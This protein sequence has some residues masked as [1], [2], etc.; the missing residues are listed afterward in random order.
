MKW[1]SD[2]PAVTDPALAAVAGGIDELCPNATV[3]GVLRHV[4]DRRVTTLVSTSDDQAIL[5]IF[6]SP[7]ARGNDRRL[8]ML[9]QAGVGDLVPTPLGHDSSGHAGLVSFRPGVI[10]ESTTDEQFVA[11]CAR[12]GIALRR[13][14]DCPAML[15]RDWTMQD[16]TR[17]L[18]RRTPASLFSLVETLVS[19]IPL[20]YDALVPS[21]RDCHPRQLIVSTTSVAWIDLDDC[22]MA[23]SGLD[24]GNMLAHLTRESILG[25]RTAEVIA[26]ARL[27][28]LLSYGWP[29]ALWRDLAGWECL[30]LARLAGLAETRFN[31][32][33]ERE[34]LVDEVLSVASAVW[35]QVF[36]RPQGG[37]SAV[38]DAEGLEDLRE[39]SFDRAF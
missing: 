21:H 16:E 4:V 26:W 11:A 33:S 20:T 12:A 27:G 39:M 7:R 6:A 35:P 22:S 10:L 2:H 14:H 37:L 13:L 8:Q 19:A 1:P 34:A 29:A 23:P 25:H 18:L 24:V 17:Q 31:S 30:S 36:G 9:V 15:D 3:V 38:G 5:K 32:P 28:F